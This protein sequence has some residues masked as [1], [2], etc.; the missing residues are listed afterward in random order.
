MSNHKSLNSVQTDK[1]LTPVYEVD[2]PE[3]K[4]YSKL[5]KQVKDYIHKWSPTRRYLDLDSLRPSQIKPERHKEL[6]KHHL[7]ASVNLNRSTQY[8]N[9][10]DLSR[11][12][13]LSR[14]SVKS[15]L[16]GAYPLIVDSKFSFREMA[17]KLE[18]KEI[19][20]RNRSYESRVVKAAQ[21]A[22]VRPGNDYMSRSHS[23]FRGSK[24]PGKTG[25]Q[26][27][28][29]G[30]GGERELGGRFQE[31]NQSPQTVHL[32]VNKGLQEDVK[33]LKL[34]I[35]VKEGELVRLRDEYNSLFGSFEEMY[36]E[37][38]DLK[39]SNKKLSEKINNLQGALR[40]SSQ[41]TRAYQ[42][43][44]R[45]LE[46][47]LDRKKATNSF[48][49]AKKSSKSNRAEDDEYDFLRGTGSVWGN[50]EGG[51]MKSKLKSFLGRTSLH[52]RDQITNFNYFEP[53]AAKTGTKGS[54]GRG[55]SHQKYPERLNTLQSSYYPKRSTLTTYSKKN[56]NNMNLTNSI[57]NPS[58]Q[59][60]M[61]TPND[62]QTNFSRPGDTREPKMSRTSYLAQKSITT[63]GGEHSSSHKI[64]L[65]SVNHTKNIDPSSNPPKR[66]EGYSLTKST[67]I[68]D[69]NALSFIK[70]TLGTRTAFGTIEALKSLLSETKKNKKFIKALKKIAE[71]LT[72]AEISKSICATNKSLWK[73]LKTFFSEYM[74]IK[75]SF[76]PNRAKS[77]LE[78]KILIEGVVETLGLRDKRRVLEKIR[79]L[80][81]D[82]FS[83][84]RLAAKVRQ[85]YMIGEEKEVGYVLKVLDGV[86]RSL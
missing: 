15:P 10:V 34:R 38:R 84:T 55:E 60:Q 58:N 26:D 7:S 19:E 65:F 75:S 42:R 51:R 67:E 6:P 2:R 64:P 59:G 57:I 44:L 30:F 50:T 86:Y 22:S 56:E 5:Q 23:R 31:S 3:P 54:A 36:R 66:S 13:N 18:Q 70:K 20:P 14:K 17:N 27:Y 74:K 32:K 45:T 78:D 25:F 52:S 79:G 71:E 29:K 40:S 8:T 82:Y 28:S 35:E 48:K 61:Q 9:P 80:K 53:R 63:G 69:A 16:N 68:D 49:L 11:T 33:N 39:A 47:S 73:W 41:Q 83:L 46:S 1:L 21:K 4:R 43:K 77:M 72:P 37:N 85:I 12:V 76:V 62:T 81:R 24:K